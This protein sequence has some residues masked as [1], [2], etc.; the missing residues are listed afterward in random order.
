MAW[1]EEATWCWH[2]RLGHLSFQALRKMAVEQWVR[3]LSK[4]EQVDKLYDEC[5]ADKYHRTTFPKRV[6]YISK[7]GLELVH[8]DLC[9]FLTL[10]TLGGKK[11]FLLMVDDF[12]RYMWIVLL[13]SKDCA[14][15]AMKRVQAKAKAATGKKL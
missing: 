4:I 2:A 14:V 6:E 9:G 13:P 3:G 5:L 15:E 8:M 12:N 1:A 11:Y 7:E 10:M